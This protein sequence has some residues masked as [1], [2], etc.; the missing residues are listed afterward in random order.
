MF[1]I[2]PDF[3]AG[4]LQKE[5]IG[6]YM[7]GFFRLTIQ[8]NKRSIKY[9]QHTLRSSTGE[10]QTVQ[11]I[12]QFYWDN[13]GFGSSTKW[14]K[15]K[16]SYHDVPFLGL[17]FHHSADMQGWVPPELME[18]LL[19][20]M[21]AAKE[22]GNHI[23]QLFYPQAVHCDTGITRAKTDSITRRC[24]NG[25]LAL[26]ESLPVDSISTKI[27]LPESTTELL[28]DVFSWL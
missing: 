1:K 24:Q 7:N 20:E 3:Q 22:S 12:N 8:A 18:M 9:C 28:T 2:S 27:S 26:S 10:S 15:N 14:L 23:P 19:T 6:L 13:L 5:G 17:C 21:K 25:P 11:R 16:V 4:M